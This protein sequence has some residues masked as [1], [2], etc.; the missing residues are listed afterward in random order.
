MNVS[1]SILIEGKEAVN[2]AINFCNGKCYRRIFNHNK[3]IAQ[4][5]PVLEDLVAVSYIEAKNIETAL[6]QLSRIGF[7]NFYALITEDTETGCFIEQND[8]CGTII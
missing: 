6:K 5:E 3:S 4:L 7:K 2:I 8:L 1:Y